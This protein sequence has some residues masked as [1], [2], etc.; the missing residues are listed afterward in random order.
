MRI[1]KGETSLFDH[2]RFISSLLAIGWNSRLLSFVLLVWAIIAVRTPNPIVLRKVAAGDSVECPRCVIAYSS[3]MQ[4]VLTL[5]QTV[6]FGD[7]WGCYVLPLIEGTPID[8]YLTRRLS[9]HSRGWTDGSRAHLGEEAKSEE[10][11]E[12]DLED[13]DQVLDEEAA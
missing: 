4:V 6:V 1:V 10:D 12:D 3:T 11:D 9:C 13:D 2:V 5:L 8:C 7:G